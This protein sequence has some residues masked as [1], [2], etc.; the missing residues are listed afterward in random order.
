MTGCD[1]CATRTHATD[2]VYSWRVRAVF[3]SI[4]PPRIWTPSRNCCRPA[5][6]WSVVR[7]MTSPPDHRP[8]S[9]A[10]ARSAM[11][12]RDAVT[13]AMG[14]DFDLVAAGLRRE[15]DGG[16]SADL[17]LQNGRVLYADRAVLNTVEGR[18]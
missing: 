3:R 6:G 4:F 13:C 12:D 1:A 9:C 7:T 16:L 10:P 11:P 15:K 5:R 2:R 14:D 18:Q 8:E 17:M